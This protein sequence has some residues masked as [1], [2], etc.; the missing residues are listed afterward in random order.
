[1]T[2][3]N[4]TDIYGAE[5]Q[6]D[7]DTRKMFEY[8][9]Q[10]GEIKYNAQ[11][12]ENGEHINAWADYI[13]HGRVDDLEAKLRVWNSKLALIYANQIGFNKN[14]ND[15]D[16]EIWRSFVEYVKANEEKFFTKT[17]DY[18]KRFLVGDDEIKAMVKGWR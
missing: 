3:K 2:I 9:N 14:Q 8:N 13:D 17:G 7:E 11:V 1:M 15:P 16:G 4:V 18:R 10:K 6:V 12:V 5:V